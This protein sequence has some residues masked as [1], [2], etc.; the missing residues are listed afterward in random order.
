[1]LLTVPMRIPIVAALIDDGRGRIFLVRKR[2]TA[3]FMLAGG[4]RDGQETPFETL[5]RELSEELHFTPTQSEVRFIGTF[6]APAANEPEYR[7]EAQIFHIRAIDRAFEVSAELEEGVWL[8]IE[9]AARLELAPLIRDHVLPV[10]RVLR[11]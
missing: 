5:V 2:G 7:V 10:A 1:M 6:S 9:E 8:S 11:G 3:A 4:K